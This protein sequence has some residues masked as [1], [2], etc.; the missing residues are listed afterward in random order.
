MTCPSVD[1][2][3]ICKLSGVGITKRTRSQAGY[4]IEPQV[5]PAPDV[6]LGSCFAIRGAEKV[7]LVMRVVEP[8]QLMAGHGGRIGVQP[9][10]EARL[11]APDSPPQG[12]D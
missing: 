3:G 2:F 5:K 12:I 6:G 9:R 11:E 7:Q 1:R 8:G 4:T 10:W